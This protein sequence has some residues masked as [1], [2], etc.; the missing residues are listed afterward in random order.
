MS[1]TQFPSDRAGRAGKAARSDPA[2]GR[3]CRGR[4]RLV[5][6]GKRRTWRRRRQFFVTRPALH[7]RRHADELP[8]DDVDRWRYL[9]QATLL[10]RSK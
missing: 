1:A 8:R 5:T 2:E 4:V 6:A 7:R 3:L 9:L 10:P